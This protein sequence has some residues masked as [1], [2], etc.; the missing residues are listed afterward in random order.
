MSKEIQKVDDEGSGQGGQCTCSIKKIGALPA[1]ANG[2]YVQTESLKHSQTCR[3]LSPHGQMV[4]MM[5]R[6]PD[7]FD[8]DNTREWRDV[9]VQFS[10]APEKKASE[11]ETD[12]R[13]RN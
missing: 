3:S 4:D 13:P 8:G 1:I 10:R 12:S 9:E 11:I 6:E 2:G 7:P 5:T